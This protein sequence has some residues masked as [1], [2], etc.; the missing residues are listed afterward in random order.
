MTFLPRAASL[1]LWLNAWLDGAASPDDVRVALGDDLRHVFLGLGSSPLA[2]VEALG[3]IRQLGSRV[4]LALPA[5]GDPVGLAGPP[6]FN[7]SAI[8][9]GQ[10]LLLPS[11]GLGFIPVQIGGAIEWHG[12]AANAPMEL[13]AREARQRL[14]Q[15]LRE[16]TEELVELQIASW[17]SDIPDL[18]MNRAHASLVP[19]ALAPADREALA[20]AELCLEIVGAARDVEPGA[21]SARDYSRFE[22][23]MRR[24]DAA[25]RRVLVALCSS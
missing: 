11:V 21:I 3:A 23:A 13:D 24:L 19:Q 14:R 7:T 1:A 20:S 5:P 9:H 6:R 12:Q 15:E 22:A 4:T 10:A 25:A 17:N 18:L 2:W 16:T 8:E